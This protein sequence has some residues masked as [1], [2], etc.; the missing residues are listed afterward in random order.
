MGRRHSNPD[1]YTW[2]WTPQSAMRLG[3]YKLLK[4]LDT[5]E[6]FLF[7]L[8]DDIEENNN[9]AKSIP[10]KADELHKMLVSYLKEVNAEKPE[11][12]R[13]TYRQDLL[14]EKNK[15]VKEINEYLKNPELVKQKPKKMMWVGDGFANLDVLTFNQ[16]RIK[17]IE[18][19]LGRLEECMD[20]A[21]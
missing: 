10:E 11:I 20:K 5:R 15:L 17:Q 21:I 16:K 13:E 1:G 6:L 8:N 9:L 12:I 18:T 3:D 14:K 19:A 7:D 4:D 2:Y